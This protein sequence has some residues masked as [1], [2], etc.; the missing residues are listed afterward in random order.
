MIDSFMK[1]P[2]NIPH[3]LFYGSSNSGKK[4]NLERLLNSIYTK[5]TKKLYTMYIHCSKCKGIKVIRDEIKDFAKQQIN[6]VP[7]K[8]IIIYDAENLTIDAQYSL[9]RCIEV[10]S[11]NTRFFIITH[12][13]DKLISPICS[14]FVQIYH[15][16]NYVKK[17][18]INV[19]CEHLNETMNETFIPL[20]LDKILYLSQTLYEEGIYGYI[21]LSKYKSHKDYVY[22]NFHYENICKELKNEKWI[23]FYILSFFNG[24]IK[25]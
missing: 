2:H 9:R 7:F 17:E 12:N 24:L 18:V 4:Y 5:E 10:Y 21:I 25:I 3:I 8:S 14:R 1:D 13:K 16:H 6:Q 11:K 22:M 19:D 15:P 20:S 23:I